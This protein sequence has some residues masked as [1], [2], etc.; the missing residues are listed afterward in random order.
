MTTSSWWSRRQSLARALLVLLAMVLAAVLNIA[1]TPAPA[2]AAPKDSTSAPASAET[3]PLSLRIGSFNVRC[4]NCYTGEGSEVPWVQRR[5][6]VV[7]TIQSQDLDVL[8]IQEASQG[9]LKDDNGD[10][11]DLSQYEDLIARL[12]SPWRLANAKRN[13]CARSESPSNCRYE[14][15]GASLGTRILYNS[16]RMAV[17]ETGSKLL[18]ETNEKGTRHY[19]TWARMQQLST[20]L[21]FMLSDSHLTALEPNAGL[22]TRQAQVALAELQAHNTDQ[23]SM[24]ALGDWN[25]TRLDA[26]SPYQVY[27]AAGFVDPLGLSTDGKGPV[28]KRVN[29]WLSSF[30]G[31]NRHAPGNSGAVAG[32]YLDHIMTTPMRVSEWET[33]ANL[34]S[35]GNFIGEIPSDHNMIR[36]TIYLPDPTA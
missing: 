28:E 24:V 29:T 9:M 19:I 16:D 10:R 12:G 6:A 14:D 20:G 21:E 32:T 25:S 27:L 30:N 8:G 18:P 34:D 4:A 15:Q 22:R 17:M 2:E 23:L 33:V 11:L 35:N 1:P 26:G 36:A 31:W 13:N 3:D 7:A 5:A